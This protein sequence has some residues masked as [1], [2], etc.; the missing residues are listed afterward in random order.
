MSATAA[1]GTALTV[2][3]IIKTVRPIIAELVQVAEKAVPDSKAGG[4]KKAFVLEWLKDEFE[5]SPKIAMTWDAFESIA[6]SLINVTVQINN[7]LSLWG[8]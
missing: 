5:A 3:Q 8:R 6:E 4:E 1:I 7:L 2:I